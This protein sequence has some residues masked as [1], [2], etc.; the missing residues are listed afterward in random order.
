MHTAQ[1]LS[2]PP[3]LGPRWLPPLLLEPDACFSSGFLGYFSKEYSPQ[4][5]EHSRVVLDAH[6]TGFEGAAALRAA[7]G[8]REIGT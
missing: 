1:V 6:G 3:P 5:A 8:L 7:Q 4:P 2:V